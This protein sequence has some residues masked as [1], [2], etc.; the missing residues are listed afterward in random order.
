MSDEDNCPCPHCG[1]DDENR[2]TGWY[3]SCGVCNPIE[4]EETE[5]TKQ[6]SGAVKEYLSVA[7]LG[8]P[9]V[10]ELEAIRQAHGNSVDRLLYELWRE[11]Q[12]SKRM[13]AKI[14]ELERKN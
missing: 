14:A 3:G 13:L 6:T 5:M 2:H 9:D 11:Q 10:A 8:I 4:K 1:C 12:L 7:V